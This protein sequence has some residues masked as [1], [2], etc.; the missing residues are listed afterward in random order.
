MKRLLAVLAGMAAFAAIPG[1]ALAHANL[2]RSEPPSNASLER[3]P[4]RVQLWFSERPEV[5]LAQVQVFDGQRKEVESGTPSAVANDPLSLVEQIRS[6]LPQGVYTVSWKVT[7]AVDGHVTAGAYAFG[8][9]VAP[10]ATDLAAAAR[11]T[12][13]PPP[14]VQGVLIRWLE[15]L[16]AA[17]LLGLA[18]FGVLAIEPA[19]GI[20]GPRLKE[21][22]ERLW[23]VAQGLAGLLLAAVM[24][25]VLDQAA[26]SGGGIT[27]VSLQAT[28]GTGIGLDL[29]ARVAVAAGILAFLLFQPQAV[30]VGRSSQHRSVGAAAALEPSSVRGA[31]A[32]R[33]MLVAALLAELLLY[34]LSSHAQAVSTPEL[35]L[36]NDWLH[37]A[38]AGVWVGGLIALSLAVVPILGS[39]LKPRAGTVPGDFDNNQS[40]MPAVTGFSRVALISAT[41]LAITG[42]YQAL[43]HVG[44]LDNALA[45]GFGQALIVKTALFAAALLLAGFH[46]WLLLP[47]LRQPAKTGATRARRFMG[48]T[49]PLETILAV[50]VLAA[51]GVVTSLPP[52]NAASSPTAQTRTLA[53]MRVVFEI[54]PL[55]VGPNEFRVTLTS[56]GRPVDNAD[57]VELQLTMLD[58]NMGPSVVDLQPNGHG[59]YSADGDVLSMSG[60]WRIDLLLRLPGQLDQRTSFDETVKT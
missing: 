21:L 15:Y 13:Q 27:P 48:R 22:N 58:M 47:L 54:V 6:G 41:G 10:S 52:A 49:L 33:G 1:A 30:A 24:A 50:G 40:F 4:A 8:V 39:R 28:L 7:S 5:K 57:K 18:L 29:L 44:S 12:Q 55:N 60:H 23:R 31:G 59:V 3:A 11:A 26:Q 2:T 38:F 42:F 53:G 36:V 19:G 51:T 17:G 35:A 34:A 45:T 14:A 56:K 46:R 32:M 9:G 37:L 43:V 16:S 25:A 20:G